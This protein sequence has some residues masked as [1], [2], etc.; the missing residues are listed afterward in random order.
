MAKE[1]QE[2]KMM[3]GGM[4]KKTYDDERWRCR[5]CSKNKK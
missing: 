1:V 4:S 5:G 2:E 3:G